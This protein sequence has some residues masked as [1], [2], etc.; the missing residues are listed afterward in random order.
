MRRGFKHCLKNVIK[1][2]DRMEKKNVGN[3]M[4]ILNQLMVTSLVT[5]IYDLNL[6]S[7][8]KNEL[9]PVFNLGILAFN[10]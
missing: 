5:V 2:K 1:L 10:D 3:E 7:K 8:A 6:I 4:H 9:L